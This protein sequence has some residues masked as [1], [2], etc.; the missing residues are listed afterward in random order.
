MTNP[1]IEY[2]DSFSWLGSK[3]GLERMHELMH[4]LGNPQDSLKFIHIAGTNGKGSTS[5]FI[6]SIL[7]AAGYKVGLFTS[8]FIH[9]FNERM[10]INGNWISDED[11][12]EVVADIRIHADSM[13]DHPTTFEL[14]TAVALKWFAVKNCDIVVLEV[15]MGG[16]YD[17]TNIIKAPEIAVITSI[18]MDHME[19][20][21][22]TIDEIAK[23]KAGIIKPGC[24][25]AAARQ[26]PEALAVLRYIAADC[27]AT[28]TQ[29]DADAIKP[30][31]FDQN[32]QQFSYGAYGN[33][34][35]GLLGHYQMENAAL[36]ITAI[37]LLNAG[38]AGG[39]EVTDAAIYKGL[40]LA[41]WPG[42]FELVPSMPTVIID[43][44]HNA[45]GGRALAKNLAR[46]FPKKDITI[47]A[48]LLED[49]DKEA[50]LSPILP[51]VKQAYTITPDNPRAL[52]ADSLAR[53]IISRGVNAIPIENI[54]HA[55][56][57]A[58]EHAGADG[59]VCFFGS[60]YSVGLAREALGLVKLDHATRKAN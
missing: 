34:S 13:Q 38:N 17:A 56:D 18:D 43:G 47:V 50:I 24:K 12:Q 33:L 40:E 32:R 9:C 39:F 60:L 7:Q 48:G 54:A 19:Y 4:S 53:Y 31:S 36:A 26:K 8:P 46:Y 44:G 20:L 37:N 45:Q 59:L 22:N 52:H 10:Q 51:L 3:L 41:K 28:L 57:K 29:I 49:K 14:V 27:D 15:G 30:I 42:R 6:A 55:L 11:L 25:V 5:C 16:T 2:L 58:K 1:S 23:N 35:I 21:G